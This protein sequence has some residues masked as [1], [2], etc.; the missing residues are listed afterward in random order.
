MRVTRQI[1]FILM[2]FIP[3]FAFAANT[4]SGKLWGTL[5]FTG[6][7]GNHKHLRYLADIS[8]RFQRVQQKLFQQSIF[9]TGLGY[10][11]N[12][13]ISLWLGYANV[14]AIDDDSDGYV[15]E[16]RFWEQGIWNIISNPSFHLS[17]R[18][19]LEQRFNVNDANWTWRIRQK[20]SFLFPQL[21]G[22]YYQPEFLD[23]VYF[24]ILNPGSFGSREFN[25]NRAFIGIQ[26]PYKKD[27]MLSIGY[28]NQY[29]TNADAPNEINHVLSFSV[30]VFN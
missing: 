30:T 27:V 9:R 26:F 11:F 24:N 15:P 25:Q 20:F 2:L 14:I 12:I 23:E 8:A 7:V 5:T 10:Q 3:L 17:W 28:L 19:R 6:Q 22:G 13:P 18:T 29:I 16:H 4:Q 21:L 1:F